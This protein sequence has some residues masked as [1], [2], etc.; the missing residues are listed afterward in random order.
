MFDGC[1]KLTGSIPALPDSLTNGDFMFS[2]CSKLTGKIPALPDSLTDGTSMFSG[3]SKLTGKTP[4]KPSGLIS[5]YTNIFQ[6]TQVTNDG[7]WPSDAW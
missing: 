2:S 1:S 6:G 7:S 5:Q 4:K 3:C